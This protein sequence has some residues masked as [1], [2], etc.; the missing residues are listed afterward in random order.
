[1]GCGETVHE[2][3]PKIT[4]RRR[5]RSSQSQKS[6]PNDALA[7]ARA[8]LM[9]ANI[10][11]RVGAEG[12]STELAILDEHRDNLVADRTGLINQLRQHLMQLEPGKK[13]LRSDLLKT[14]TLQFYQTYQAPA[15][16]PMATTRAIVVRQLAG[17]ILHLNE[18]I[19][20]LKKELTLR[21]EKSQTPLLSLQGV[22]VLVA[23]KILGRIGNINLFSSSANLASYAGISPFEMSSGQRTQHRVNLG[24]DRQ[25]NRAF[26]IIAVVQIRSNAEAKAYYQRKIAQG[27]TKKEALRCLKRRLVDIVFAMLS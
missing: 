2:V 6:D 3:S 12:I 25:L 23:A 9:D 17:Q 27:K 11:P 14:E 4:A 21:V 24:G 8:Y 1:V 5:R 18:L 15:G 16:D 13:L 19:E 26:H 10:L 20:E 22:D 7:I